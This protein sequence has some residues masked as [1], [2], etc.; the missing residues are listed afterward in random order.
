MSA[1]VLADAAEEVV[2]VE[3]RVYLIEAQSFV[4]AEIRARDIGIKDE[5]AGSDG[6]TVNG[7]LAREV[8]LGVRHV[9]AIYP[10]SNSAR[11]FDDAVP[12]HGAEIAYSNF[13]VPSLDVA[14]KMAA[15]KTVEVAILGDE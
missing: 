5:E 3:E 11:S 4:E 10:P 13:K 12:E 1:T 9:Q 6:Q 14:R 8:F 7:K 15:G 2:Q